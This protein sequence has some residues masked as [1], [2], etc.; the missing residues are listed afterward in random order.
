MPENVMEIGRRRF[1]QLMAVG[2]VGAAAP[3][4]WALLGRSDGDDGPPQILYGRDRCEAC[5]MV[6]S[7]PRFA[8]AARDGEAVLRYDDIGCLIRHRGQ[9]VAARRA[10]AFVHDAATEEWLPAA[11]AQY[12]RSPRI[13]T[14]MN[15]GIAAYA[16][17]AEAHRAYPEVSPDTWEAVLGTQARGSS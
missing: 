3:A 8:A 13:K 5:G 12:V 11:R 9:R 15:H 17:V 6:I 1:L 10:T 14:P 7:D 4:A 2:V 16:D